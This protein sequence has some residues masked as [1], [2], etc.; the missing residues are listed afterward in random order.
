MANPTLRGFRALLIL[1][2]FAAFLP[3]YPTAR[4]AAAAP[5]ADCGQYVA[6]LSIPDGTQVAPGQTV[7][8]G[9]RL[10]NC[11]TTTWSGY[12]AV[13]VSGAYGPASFSVP[14]T[15]AGAT[16]DLWASITAP[17]SAGTYRATYQ[18]QSAGGVR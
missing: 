9:W 6:D 4:S 5:T 18:L 7:S 14:A 8:K 10:R 11:G 16:G 12:S 3:T 15:G 1:F 17:A 13:R 2:F